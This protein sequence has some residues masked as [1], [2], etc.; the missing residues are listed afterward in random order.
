LIAAGDKPTPV[1]VQQFMNP[2]LA[3]R[4]IRSTLAAIEAAGGKALY[5]SA[6]VT[7]SKALK[8][9]V[10]SA[11]KTLGKVSGIIHG[12]G[13]LADKL[14]EQKTVADFDAV[15]RTKIDGLAA[16]LAAVDQQQLRHLVLFSSAAGFYGNPAQSDYA[17]ANE[18]LNKTALRFKAL[19]PQAQVLSFNWGPW[20]GGMVTDALK[21]MFAERGVYI[22]PIDAGA[23]LMVRELVAADNR[24]P[25]ILVGNDMSGGQA[26]DEGVRGKKPEVS[27]LYKTLKAAN[28]PFLADHRIGGNSVLPTVC[29]IAWM[30]DAAE[31]VY[32]AWRC[33][34]V[35]DY[36]LFK[37][38]V[39]D[40]SEAGRYA[41]EVKPLPDQGNGLH[42]EVKVSSDGDQ[43]R[44]QFHYGAQL[45]LLPAGQLPA[46]PH[47]AGQLEAGE[48][49]P[50][51]RL[52]RDGTLF[53]GPSLQGIQRIRRCDENGL[54]LLC[55]V[56][57]AALASQ[58]DFAV[59]RHNVFADDLV[60]QAMLVW[61]REQKGLGS[62]PSATGSW[63]F[64]RN[65]AAGERFT[66][67]LAVTDSDNSKVL[68]D[69]RLI[70]E[71]GELLAE[72][73]A[74]QVTASESLNKLFQPAA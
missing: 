24:C 58:G 39:L 14:I 34:Q 64:Y 41:I 2:L 18:I 28:N 8:K 52:Y 3:Q 63:T 53:H 5:V 37:G 57:A 65:I 49:E 68:A 66:L 54:E 22:I 17:I 74:A 13:V 27:R 15:Y 72:V 51:A 42:L 59:A 1:K 20:D 73:H 48:G 4:E 30:I 7:D 46:A 9:A 10:S 23:E 61:V 38:I 25:Q 47:F 12:A 32:S 11:E 62:L 50:A 33:V 69:I 40:G 71:N 43:G 45:R 16:M 19:H 55:Q 6:D 31:S 21:R 60:Y 56:P 44:P 36:R 70:G 26:A 29:A 35:T 67:Q